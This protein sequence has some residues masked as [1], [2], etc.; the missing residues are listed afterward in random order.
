MAQIINLNKARKKKAREAAS[1]QADV[2]RVKFGR[3]KEQKALEAAQAE[4]AQRKL[5]QLRREPGEPAG[6]VED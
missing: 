2:N 6:P 5:D 4:E 3:T 1:A